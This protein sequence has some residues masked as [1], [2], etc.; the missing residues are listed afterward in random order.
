MLNC[1]FMLLLFRGSLHLLRGSLHVSRGSSLC[2]LSLC[3][4]GL[5][6]CGELFDFC[7][8]CVEPFAL[9]LGDRDIFIR[10]I[11]SFTFGSAFDHLS[12][13]LLVSFLFL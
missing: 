2:R 7:L 4:G 3:L 11:Q 6:L 13:S 5:L 9:V 8:G 12:G 10:V 1:S